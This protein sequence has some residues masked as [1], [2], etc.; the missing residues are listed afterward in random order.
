MPFVKKNDA[1]GSAQAGDAQKIFI[2]RSHE[3]HFFIEHVLQPEDP[4]YNIISIYGDGGVGKSTLLN[5]YNEE[6]QSSGYKEYCLT[7]VVDERQATPASMMER[8]ADQLGMQSEFRRALQAYKDALRK[9]HTE[10]ETM[11]DAVLQHAPDFA[12]AAVEGVP[13]VGPLLREG[14]KFGTAQAI[15]RYHVPRTV[16]RLEDPIGDLTRAFVAE[17]NHLA[18]AQVTLSGSRVRRRHRVLLFF[19]TFEQLEEEA[20]PW[21]LDY[22]LTADI[23]NSV[24]LI[25]AGR[26]PI[27]RSLARDPKRWLPYRENGVLYSFTLNS[28]TEAETR[29]YLEQRGITDPGRIYQIWQLSRG[30]PLYLSLLTANPQHEVDPTADVVA[31]FLRWIPEHEEVKLRL[32]LDAALFTLPFNQDDL[33]ALSYIHENDR[34]ALYQWLIKQPFVHSS[35]QDGRYS[36]H[37]MAEDLF[38]RH[39]IR[40]SPNSYYATRRALAE[41]YALCIE[42]LRRHGKEVYQNGAWLSMMVALAQQLLLLPDMQS[43]VQ[44]SEHLLDAYY[45]TKQDE[46]V[47][48]VLRELLQERPYNTANA[49]ARQIA[50]ILLNY[51]EA[52]PMS[53]EFLLASN[54]L[55]QRVSEVPSFSPKVLAQLYGNRGVTQRNLNEPAAAIAD[56]DQAIKHDPRYAWAYGNRGITHRTLKQYRQALADLDKALSLDESM[57]WVYVTRG[58]VL[59]HLKEY[60]RAV[61]DFTRA[62]TLDRDY[63][64]AYAGRGRVYRLLK[65]YTEAI[66]DLQRAIALDPEMAWAYASLGEVYRNIGENRRAIEEYDRAIALAPGQH[67]FWAY[68][69][70]GLAY[71]N[72]QDYQHAQADFDYAI[73]LNP[74]YSWGYGH[75][76]RMYRHLKQYERALVDM[77]R[78]I[79][80]AP[81]DAWIRSHRGLVF[82]SL[83]NYP[84]AI[85]DLSRSIALDPTYPANYARRGSAYLGEGNLVKAA[86]DYALN[87]ELAP[88]DIRACWM[89]QWIAM[90]QQRADKATATRLE[91]IATSRSQHYFAYVCRGVANWL[92]GRQV[93]SALE[94]ACRM[95]E[96]MWDAFFWRGL[97]RAASGQTE[98]IQDV[99]HALQLGMFPA[100][101]APLSWLEQDKPDFYATHVLPLLKRYH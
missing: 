74:L 33:A 64:Q 17:L 23:S 67:Y 68:G 6:A 63:A 13:F 83:R 57:D 87:C 45:R 72:L 40:I 91:E 34:P 30:L 5:R 18:E 69:S 93:G 22:F 92:H 59:R 47:T 79:E 56:F 7:A 100:L 42:Q 66:Q 36:Y 32:V 84:R 71:F 44:A 99:E 89:T 86:Y 4:L 39:L 75:R 20:A 21:L 81:D 88:D 53:E 10:Q 38:G 24:V 94:D 46:E 55:L 26:L 41:Y 35:G 8:F 76:G 1:R 14:I 19:D 62:I 80:L 49:D 101:L 96:T 78:A 98:G 65:Q 60:R 28:F 25:V 3:L 12:G 2:A 11:E 48:R 29:A 15:N 73:E 97:I 27:E 50:R 9:L 31:N 51:I 90:C 52:M 82:I 37:E 58:E 43:H 85:D 77:N 61:A 95:R 70:R 16:E 54:Q